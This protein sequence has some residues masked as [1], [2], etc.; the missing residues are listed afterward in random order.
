[1]TLRYGADEFLEKLDEVE[2]QL[3][4]P[5]YEV[6]HPYEATVGCVLEG[7]FIVKRILGRGA[8]AVALLVE[9]QNRQFVL[10]VARS[11]D[12]NA[13]IRNEF[14]LLKSLGWPQLIEV[15]ALHEF[16]DLLGISMDHAG[17]QTLARQIRE[18]GA[19]D[20]TLLRQFGEDLL[21]TVRYLDENGVAH[22]DIKPDNIGVRVG[23]T[24]KRNE[25]CLFD[26]SLA[27]AP[28]ENISIGTPPY[29]D[30]FLC[31]RKVKRW[32]TKSELFSVAMTLHEMATGSL[33]KWGDG[34]A[35]PSLTKGEVN[36]VG[37]LF[38][39]ELHARF[40]FFF[41]KA[42]RP[43]YAERFDNLE[44]MLNEWLRIFETIDEP[45]RPGPRKKSSNGSP[46]AIRRPKRFPDIPNWM[47]CLNRWASI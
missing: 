26:F 4:R 44:E 19:L 29:L 14:E 39:S 25:L 22:R 1:M 32:N 13:R 9:Q 45:V 37:E 34:R 15:H 10:K 11:P 30:P 23:K 40:V 2:E 12:S 24:K 17:D 46:P 18:D 35:V 27:G 38:P 47:A 20:L 36:L 41:A 31:E 16:D 28:A 42:L 5:D 43:N 8:T 3:T 33:P 21:R 6:V 7:G